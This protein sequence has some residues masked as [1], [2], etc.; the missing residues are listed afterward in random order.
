MFEDY[1]NGM[2]IDSTSG[3]VY[4]SYTAEYLGNDYANY[5]PSSTFEDY[6]NGMVI[7]KTN[8][9]VYDSNTAELVGNDYSNYV[10]ENATG[11]LPGYNVG[12]DGSVHY[13]DGTTINPDG[14]ISKGGQTWTV[15]QIKKDKSLWEQISGTISGAASGFLKGAGNLL[16]DPNF[17]KAAGIAGVG[18]AGQIASNNANESATQAA[19]NAIT[20]QTAAAD[21]AN[22]LQ[23][24]QFEYAK[25]TNQPFY[26]KGLAG[27]NQYAS[28]VT[29]TPGADG[30]VWSPT[31]TPAY[32]WQQQQMEKNTGR[33]LRSLGRENSTYGMNV[34]ADQ[35]RNLAATEY[36]KQ[37]GR[38]ADLTNIARGGAS[39]LTGASSQ[40]G[41]NVANNLVQSGNNQA[42][43]ALATGALKQNN[44][45]NNQQNLM[46]LANL[47]LKA[48]GK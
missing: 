30:K 46:S 36:D 2:V 39:S 48:F 43:A 27:F 5:T 47:G 14:T 3:D 9:N 1:G 42:D 24:D 32:Q 19:N 6:G 8:G 20:A 15:D 29:G 11:P 37:L 25:T 16:S 12:V 26:D 10:N 23:R 40:Y 41:T 31:E 22:Q 38:L 45:Y 18:I 28:A 4:D 21:K 17:L 44:L 34:M 33:T 13:G 35:N 7:D